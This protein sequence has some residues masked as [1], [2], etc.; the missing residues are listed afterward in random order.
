M[1]SIHRLTLSQQMGTKGLKHVVPAGRWG[2]E[3]PALKHS[4]LCPFE[5]SFT[6]HRQAN[7]ARNLKGFDLSSEFR[8]TSLDFSLPVERAKG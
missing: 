7:G 8:L 5:R 4:L 1:Y 2:I 3:I 6:Q